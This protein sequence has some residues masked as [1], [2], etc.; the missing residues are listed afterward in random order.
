MQVQRYVS[1][2]MKKSIVYF[3]AAVKYSV[4][5]NTKHSWAICVSIK[6]IQINNLNN[7]FISIIFN[8]NWLFSS[9]TLTVNIDDTFYM[10]YAFL[11]NTFN[12]VLKPIK[13]TAF[14]SYNNSLVIFNY[15]PHVIPKVKLGNHIKLIIFA[16]H[17]YS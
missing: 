7:R 4:Y 13:I 10:H 14:G 12:T 6:N 8:N 15:A 1:C 11:D 16:H 2:N 17:A 5:K 9:L 3:K